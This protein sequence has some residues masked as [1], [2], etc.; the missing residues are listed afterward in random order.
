MPI[1]VAEFAE[2]AK[3]LGLSQLAI[4]YLHQ[5]RSSA[6][7]RR[8]E[9]VN[10][11][12]TVWRYPSSKMG[13]TIALE[14]SEEF[15]L[16]V[17]LE[18]DPDVVEYWEQ[19]P[20]VAL[21]VLDSKGRRRRCSY[22]PDFL[23]MRRNEAHVIQVKPADQC[24]RLSREQ[25]RRWTWDG[26][27]AKDVA[28]S[29]HFFEI[30][31]LHLIYSAGQSHKIR[32]DNYRLMLQVRGA[33]IE[34]SA[35]RKLGRILS[36][37]GPSEVLSMRQLMLAADISTATPIVRLIEQGRLFTDVDHSR[38]SVPSECFISRSKDAIKAQA[39]ARAALA[40]DKEDTA[41]L[42]SVE[43]QEAHHRL[44]VLRGEIPTHRCRRS[45]RRWKNQLL[46]SGG[47]PIALRPHHR[48]KGN[49]TPRL[50]E[51]EEFL[52]A[53][54]LRKHYLSSLCL[55]RLAA[56]GQY[57]VDH[58]EAIARGELAR[59]SVP[60]AYGTYALRGKRI[61]AEEVAA[62]RSGKRA[63][64]A[65]AHPVAPSLKHLSPVRAFERAHVD[66]YLCDVHVVVAEGKKRYT[67]RPQLTAMRDQ[68]TGSVLAFSLS[69]MAPSRHSCLGVIRD[70]VRRH[71]RLPEIIVVDNGAEFHAEYFEVVLGRLGV[72]IQRRPPGCPRYG[73]VIEGWFH[74]LKAFLSSQL[75]NTNNDNRE[76]SAVMT[77]KGRSHADWTLAEAHDA[78]DRFTFE[79]FNHSAASADV[80]T[81]SAKSANALSLFPESGVLTPFST[82]FL[83]LTAM[84]L[85]KRLKVD[86]ARGI[87][88]LGRWFTHP[89]L[90]DIRDCHAPLQ[91]FE[92]P[93]DMN[94]LYA[95]VDG[96]LVT[97][98]HGSPSATDLSQDFTP[99]LA[100]IRHLECSNVRS[101]LRKEAAIASAELTRQLAAK[102]QPKQAQAK[103]TKRAETR[104][105]LPTRHVEAAPLKTE[106]WS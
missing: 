29:E 49:R 1:T 100:S 86:L 36:A 25:P 23:V 19:P 64:A 78:I 99:A 41:Q 73:G 47:N 46:A 38:L 83:A 81:R 2:Y 26:V 43:L 44:L 66:H 103:P 28:A 88:H 27:E 58:Q 85:K 11:R 96:V 106:Y 69:F 39:S 32:V 45:I 51:D 31:L 40:V 82:D 37:L 97:C 34:P 95:L 13:S 72:T 48:R 89:K 50:S 94:V 14:S 76:R 33:E 71:G 92:E 16:A 3:C 67:Q 21:V 68:A 90:F 105:K 84:P 80:D 62:S 54:S 65:A 63:A 59:S 35:A 70:C 20:S 77:H 74:S 30:G 22:V 15:A 91:I 93:W 7:S 104:R 5:T 60:V 42:S 75:G 4:A 102:L 17:Q 24:E 10:T 87:R 8:V 61:P 9:S 55:S 53:S 101:A 57:L 79:L 18:Y 12:N 52:L 56:Y 98:R 6:P